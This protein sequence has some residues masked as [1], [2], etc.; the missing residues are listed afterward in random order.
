MKI[1]LITTILFIIGTI[2]AQKY[3]I[4]YPERFFDKDPVFDCY[5]NS[6][7]DPKD[8]RL[9]ALYHETLFEKGKSIYYP[10]FILKTKNSEGRFRFVYMEKDPTKLPPGIRSQL[11]IKFP[12]LGSKSYYFHDNSRVFPEN[13][14]SSLHYAIDSGSIPDNLFKKENIEY[15]DGD[16]KYINISFEKEYEDT[17]IFP[18]LA[19]VYVV[20]KSYNTNYPQIGSGLF[21]HDKHDE[22]IISLKSFN[23]YTTPKHFDSVLVKEIPLYTTMIGEFENEN[24]NL[25][26]EI[27]QSLILPFDLIYVFKRIQ[28]ISGTAL[29][30][31]HTNQHLKK[32]KFREALAYAIKRPIILRNNLHNGGELLNGP[33]PRN[34][35]YH[36]SVD[37]EIKFDL[38]KAKEILI[39]L[40]YIYRNHQLYYN[41]NMVKLKFVVQDAGGELH[42]QAENSIGQN[43]RMLGITVDIDKKTNFSINQILS[44]SDKWDL[45][46]KRYTITAAEDLYEYYHSKGSQNYQNYVNPDVDKL[47][48]GM[49][50]SIDPDFKLEYGKKINSLLTN[51]YASIYLW[52]TYSWYG[53]NAKYLDKSIKNNIDPDL[54]FREPHKWKPRK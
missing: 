26:P 9:F 30:I 19:N 40:G 39:N 24:I 44:R 28:K 27:P 48:A 7:R 17:F 1:K 42:M 21:E 20:P 49:R 51:D 29:W 2:L 18:Y 46:Y 33:F 31:D 10:N 3:K 25:L 14:I 47:Y 35:S 41:D 43:L 50:S 54:F 12:N 22:E 36:E 38:V 11:V 8:L 34:S 32:S 53:Y 15:I 52:S 45:Y 4:I 6:V 37:Q 23:K 16:D 5:E 13:I